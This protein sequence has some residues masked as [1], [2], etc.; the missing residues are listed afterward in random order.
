MPIGRQPTPSPVSP[1]EDDEGKPDKVYLW[2]FE[3]LGKLGFHATTAHQLAENRQVDLER[4]R[5]L[6]KKGC[7]LK[8][9]EEILA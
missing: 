4:A 7:S 8:L 6:R 5:Q 3:Q 1:V 2:R 9:I